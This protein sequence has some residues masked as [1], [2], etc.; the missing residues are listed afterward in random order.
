MKAAAAGV[1]YVSRIMYCIAGVALA[2]IVLLVVA[3]VVLRRFRLPI[4]CTFEVVVLLAAVVISF[5]LPQSTLDGAHVLTDFLV[6]KLS[7]GWK[8]GLFAATRLL[9]MFV[10]AVFAWR[11]AAFGA[12]MARAGEVSPILE[13]PEHFVVFAVA[14]CCVVECLVLAV[15]LSEGLKGE[16]A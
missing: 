13:F 14:A 10:F 12:E 5:S 3:D 15:D 7:A 16:K 6:E 1:R 11:A 8:K 9:G 4:D 2:S